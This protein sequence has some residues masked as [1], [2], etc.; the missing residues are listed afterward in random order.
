MT[1]VSSNDAVCLLRLRTHVPP[2]P[3]FPAVND[4]MLNPFEKDLWSYMILSPIMYLMGTIWSMKR[5]QNL[6]HMIRARSTAVGIRSLQSGP[7]LVNINSL[8]PDN[9][10]YILKRLYARISTP[11]MYNHT[12]IK[13]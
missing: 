13:L 6:I 10:I 4:D 9:F 7:G 12:S 5:W 8:N 1:C 3:T 11:K 2:G